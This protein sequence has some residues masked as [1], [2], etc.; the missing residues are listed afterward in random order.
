MKNK[1]ISVLTVVF[2]SISMFGCAATK[3]ENDISVIEQIAQPLIIENKEE[4]P[5]Q[6]A[7]PVGVYE[8]S[9]TITGAGVE[10]IK[11][12]GIILIQQDGDKIRVVSTDSIREGAYE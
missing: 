7:N 10:P 8:G 12:E 6:Q 9:I 5:P 3:S 1:L 11:Y 4:E 2:L